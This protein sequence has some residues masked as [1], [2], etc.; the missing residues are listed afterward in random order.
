MWGEENVK[1]FT[2]K[3]LD[4][5]VTPFFKER[6]EENIESVHTFPTREIQMM[7]IGNPDGNLLAVAARDNLQI[8]LWKSAHKCLNMDFQCGHFEK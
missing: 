5:R 6:W 8:F 3:A 7:H 2:D 4:E 1:K